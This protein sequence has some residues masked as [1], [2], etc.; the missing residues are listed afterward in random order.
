M[1]WDRYSG[2]YSIL[3]NFLLQVRVKNRTAEDQLV[4]ILPLPADSPFYILHPEFEVGEPMTRVV[5]LIQKI[6]GPVKIF[7]VILYSDLQL[8]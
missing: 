7:R 5:I 8:R 4:R 3:I 6:S 1:K 2:I